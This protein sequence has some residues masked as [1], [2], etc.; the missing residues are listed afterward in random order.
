MKAKT[1]AK[2][3]KSTLLKKPY[4]RGFVWVNRYSS[5][6]ATD[7]M[8]RWAR[9]GYYNGFMISWITGFVLQEGKVVDRKRIGVCNMFLADLMFPT[10][11]NQGG[12][13]SKFNSIDD[14]KK[15]SEEMFNDFK[16]LINK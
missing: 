4:N 13:S 8:G 16:K 9:I 7:I 10:S 11:S 15:W 12:D 5:N 6:E 1:K 14:A 3:N 2:I